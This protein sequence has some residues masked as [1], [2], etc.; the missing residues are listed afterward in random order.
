MC[1]KN[2]VLTKK[3]VLDECKH[4]DKSVSQNS[5]IELEFIKSNG[6]LVDRW[7]FEKTVKGKDFYINRALF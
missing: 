6:H 4:R 3:Q 1:Y 7:I 2:Q 5:L